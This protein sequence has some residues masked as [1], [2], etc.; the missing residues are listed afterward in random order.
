MPVKSCYVKFPIFV[1]IFSLFMKKV[2]LW[3]GIDGKSLAKGVIVQ[4]IILRGSCQKRVGIT[5]A[6][7]KEKLYYLNYR[8]SGYQKV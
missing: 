2:D 6:D 8:K 3:V 5:F 4:H 1:F 7:A